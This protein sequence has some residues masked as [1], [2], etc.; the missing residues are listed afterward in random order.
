MDTPRCPGQDQRYW[1][2]E[3]IFD[4]VCPACGEAI[5]FWKDEP[6]R[7]CSACGQEVGNPRMDFGCAKWCRFAQDCVGEHQ[8]PK[9]EETNHLQAARI[10][11]VRRT[12]ERLADVD[13]AAAAGRGGLAYDPEQGVAVSLLGRAFYVA[14]GS[15]DVVAADG[16]KVSPVDELLILRYLET[17]RPVEPTGRNITF[18]DLPGGNFYA[19]A[20]AKRTTDLIEKTFGDSAARLR[21]AFAR[22]PHTPIE[23]GDAGACFHA[24]GRIDVTLVLHAGD[25]EFPASAQIFYDQVIASVYSSDEVA[26]LTTSLCV[27]LVRS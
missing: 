11:A 14:P 26:A 21:E 19:V 27:G 20:L 12:R 7:V 8:Q 9:S 24:I 17:A 4:V 22:F 23:R 15:L 10:E 1:K 16:G 3:D 2:P 13:L 18:R 25:D 6:K 5:E